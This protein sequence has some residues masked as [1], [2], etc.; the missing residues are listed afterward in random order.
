MR[1]KALSFRAALQNV[2]WMVTLF[3]PINT[4]PINKCV[5]NAKKIKTNNYNNT[6]QNK[7]LGWGL[8]L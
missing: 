7:T 8:L 2:G 6:D 4:I 3:L 5:R 1:D